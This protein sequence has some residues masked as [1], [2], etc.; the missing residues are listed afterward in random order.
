MPVLSHAYPP[1]VINF[2]KKKSAERLK[3]DR[4]I[5]QGAHWE[6]SQQDTSKERAA[7]GAGIRPGKIGQILA[8]EGAD[9]HPA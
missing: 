9:L 1:G 3:Q 4:Q 5:Q 2:G 8:G 6:A 7:Q